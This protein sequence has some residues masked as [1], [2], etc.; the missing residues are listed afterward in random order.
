MDETIPHYQQVPIIEWL[1]NWTEN[2]TP[3]FPIPSFGVNLDKKQKSNQ[4]VLDDWLHSG[5]TERTDGECLCLNV[6]DD[7]TYPSDGKD[8]QISCKT[9]L[10]KDLVIDGIHQYDTTNTCVL[11]R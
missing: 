2:T 8:T 5:N 7:E 9:D 1:T 3:S 11:V 10:E 6:S 4:I